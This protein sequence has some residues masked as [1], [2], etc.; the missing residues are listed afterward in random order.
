MLYECLESSVLSI[1]ADNRKRKQKKNEQSSLKLVVVIQHN[2]FRC[3]TF[4]DEMNTMLSVLIAK[5]LVFMIFSLTS[6]SYYLSR[7]AVLSNNAS[8]C[9]VDSIK[10]SFIQH[11][12]IESNGNAA[13]TAVTP[14]SGA[15]V[16]CRMVE[17]NNN[18]WR[19]K[20]RQVYCRVLSGTAS[21]SIVD[22]INLSNQTI[23]NQG[24]RWVF[25]CW[26]PLFWVNSY[27]VHAQ[28]PR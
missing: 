27:I 8:L 19:Q 14:L 28:S 26:L 5:F 12:Y 22:V 23:N 24:Y 17:Y 1:S 11:L 2:A 20:G 15:A 18:G 10:I 6:I 21:S 7:P 13:S 4:L 3:A 16:C 9:K 25:V